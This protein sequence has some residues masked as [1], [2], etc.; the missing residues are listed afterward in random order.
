[1]RLLVIMKRNLDQ[2]LAEQR[3]A[4][5][6]HM[7]EIYKHA[8]FEPYF[9]YAESID[10]IKLSLNNNLPDLVLCGI[11]HL[12][13]NGCNISHNVHAW[14]EEHNVNYIGSDYKV[15]EL[16]LSKGLLK[17][18]WQTYGI[19][20]PVFGLIREKPEECN[21]DIESLLS[22]DAFPYILKPENLGNSRGIDENSIVWNEAELRKALDKIRLQFGGVILAEHYLGASADFREIT[23]AMI[24]GSS[25]MLFMPAEV[26]LVEPKRFHIITTR[27]KD[28]N[29]TIANPLDADTAASFLPFAERVF[30][31]AGVRDYSRGDFILAD[32]ELW[33]IEINGQPMIPDQWF[34]SAALFAGLSE[35][36][37]LVGIV[38]SGYRRLKAEGRLAQVFPKEAQALLKGTKLEVL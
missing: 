29:G 12:P 33:A 23:C 22:L 1:M 21:E 37:Y 27:D 4:R 10:D 14:F 35:E 28:K 3:N 20:T 24:E 15:I 36:K 5:Y 11:D 16:A 6:L 30:A 31:I 8:G 26:S 18:K 19:R 32:G 2:S 34:S 25:G 9:S 7:I 13:E 17:Q 38:A